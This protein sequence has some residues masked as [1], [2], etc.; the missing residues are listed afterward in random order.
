MLVVVSYDVADDRRR[1]KVMK[2]MKA[3]GDRVQLSVFECN[4][5]HKEM[6]RMCARLSRAIKAE[7]DTVR[8]YRICENCKTQIRIMGRGVVSED[9]ELIIV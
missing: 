6:Q 3:F 5:E 4:F 2:A 7:E 8:I 9:P 1:L